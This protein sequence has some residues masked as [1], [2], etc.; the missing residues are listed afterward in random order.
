MTDST[1]PEKSGIHLT[2]KDS[3]WPVGNVAGEPPHTKD[4]TGAD[5]FPAAQSVSGGLVTDGG[6][7]EVQSVKVQATGGTYKLTFETKQTAAIA[8]DATA[9]QVKAALEA[10]DNIAKG[11]V[12]VT[13]GPGD[14]GG[15]KPYVVT[16]E[17][18]YADKNVGSLTADATALTGGEHKVTVTTSTAGAPL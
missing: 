12:K 6:T 7:N 3:G 13:G 10:L 9:A 17:G 4:G 18:A 8:F 2:G 14:E 15:T 1:I 11:D 16:F 5:P